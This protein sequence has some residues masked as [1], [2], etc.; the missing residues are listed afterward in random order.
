MFA[1][2]PRMELAVGE[3]TALMHKYWHSGQNDVMAISAMLENMKLSEHDMDFLAYHAPSFIV[4]NGSNRLLDLRWTTELSVINQRAY[5]E[6]ALQ[7]LR[8]MYVTLLRCGFWELYGRLRQLDGT[9][10]ASNQCTDELWNMLDPITPALQ[11]PQ[12]AHSEAF[13]NQVVYRQIIGIRGD[14][15]LHP[16]DA[17]ARA[18]IPGYAEQLT[19]YLAHNKTAVDHMI[20]IA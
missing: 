1:L 14:C 18:G 8:V 19:A 15:N 17:L 16:L 5:D 12:Q 10:C 2:D 11:Q 4:Y 6:Y 20:G 13:R 9:I 3:L 7:I